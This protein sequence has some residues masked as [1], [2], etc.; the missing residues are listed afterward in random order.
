MITN[1]GKTAIGVACVNKNFSALELLLSSCLSYQSNH[2]DDECGESEAKKWKRHD[3]LTFLSGQYDETPD[4]MDD[5]QWEDEIEQPQ[6]EQ[7]KEDT[8]DDEWSVLYRY[9][10]SIIEKTG[11]MLANTISMR[12]PHC[13]DA[14]QQAPIHYAATVGSYECM[15]LLLN[16]NAPINMTTNIGYTAL[17]LAVEQPKIV[18]LLLQYKANPN[19]LTFYDQLAP[20]HMA[21][22]IGIIETVKKELISHKKP[23]SLPICFLFFSDPNAQRCWSKYKYN[24]SNRSNSVTF[25]DCISKI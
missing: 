24:N 1:F 10:A 15:E 22:K 17:H 25:G 12:E 5:M 20:I 21:A 13:L 16:H 11:E 14:F 2:Y 3:E 4:G 19:K 9:Y 18:E 6:T 7:I 23:N 8:V